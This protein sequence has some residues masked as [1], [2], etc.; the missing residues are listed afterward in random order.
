MNDYERT[1]DDI[2][3]TLGLV[4]GFMKGLP[5]NVLVAEWPMFKQ[6][7]IEESVIP[8]R[9]RELMGLAVAANIKCPYCQLFHREAAKMMG[10]TEDE[11]AETALLSGW[12]A[13]WSSMIHAQHYDY[14]VFE[15]EVQ[16]IGAHLQKTAGKK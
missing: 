13:F 4:P 6:Y 15:Q 2:K 1:L 8:P 3:K 16:K 7:Q 12:V 14:E 5:K 11:L 10:A 9:Y